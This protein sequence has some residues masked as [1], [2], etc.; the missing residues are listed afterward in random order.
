MLRNTLK[1]HVDINTEEKQKTLCF[2]TFMFD[3]TLYCEKK[4]SYRYCLQ[5]FSTEKI[6]KLQINDCFKINSKQIIQMPKEGEY[7]KF[8]NYERKVKSPFMIYVDFESI[9]EA[10]EKQN[11][12]ES[13]TNKYQKHVACSYGYKSN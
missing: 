8:K 3:H 7:V 5:T 13:Y 10:E 9:L 11:S 1:R 12:D 6:L 2:N 4:H